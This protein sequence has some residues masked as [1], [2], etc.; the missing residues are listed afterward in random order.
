MKQNRL[1]QI[2]WL[3][4]IFLMVASSLSVW[5]EVVRDWLP[6]VDGPYQT[7]NACRRILAGQIPGRDFVVFHGL[8]LNWYHVPFYALL[9]GNIQADFRGA[10]G[11]VWLES[12]DDR[13]IAHHQRDAGG[14]GAKLQRGDARG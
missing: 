2:A 4:L 1:T 14:A 13:R 9:G 7:A 10:V 5:S 3:T 6:P 11:W 12:I 8:G